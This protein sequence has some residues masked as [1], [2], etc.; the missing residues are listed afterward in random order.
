MNNMP[1]RLSWTDFIFDFHDLLLEKQVEAPMYIVGGAVRDAYR[2]GAIKDVDIAVDGDAVA[3]ARR[4]A[5][6]FNGDIFVM[7]KERG[8]ARVFIDTLDGQIVM[9][10]ARFRGDTLDDDLHDRDFTINAMA[11]DLLGDISVLID[12]LNG[13]QD[14]NAKVLQK[15]SDHAIK[16]DAIRV[17]RAIRQSVQLKLRIHPDTLLDVRSNIAGLK[18]SSPERIRDEFYKILELSNPSRAIRVLQHLGALSYVIPNSEMLIGI[19]QAEPHRGDVWN[20][21]VSVIQRMNAILMSISYKRTDNTAANF[22]LGM[23]VIQ[24]DRYR[25][26]LQAHVAR[27]YGNGRTHQQLLILG[28]LL[29]NLGKR[30]SLSQ[31]IEFS[32]KSAGETAESL[33]LTNDERKNLQMM[34]KMY[35]GVL[36]HSEWSD[37]DLHRFWFP[38]QE[39]GI[40][41]ILL[42][43][44]DYLAMYGAELEQHKWLEIVERA[45]ILLDTYFNKYDSIVT[46]PLFLDGNAIMTLLHIKGS[47]MVGEML[48]LLREAQVTGDVVSEESARDFIIRQAELLN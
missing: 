37:L 31:H 25:A 40:D 18:E 27:S 14:L 23:I 26:Q 39:K 33:R 34:I 3:V 35:R 46:P 32:V 6:W 7:D 8:V 21:T 45:T 12:P 17:L 1:T 13:E 10:F 2:G 47:P 38:L 9:D 28:A 24:F 30:E 19:A 22:D 42:A 29:H 48:S 41:A 15:C 36:E 16:D 43:I 20:H 5:D 4:I 11:V 44:A